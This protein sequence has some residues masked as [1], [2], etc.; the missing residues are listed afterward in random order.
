MTWPRKEDITQGVLDMLRVNM[1]WKETEKLVIVS[2]LPRLE[3][4]RQSEDRKLTEALERVYLARL[5]NEIA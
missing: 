3:D 2:D 5:V 1:N 4:W